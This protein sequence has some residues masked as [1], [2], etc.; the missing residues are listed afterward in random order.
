MT[1]FTPR[2][3]SAPQPDDEALRRM[4][5]SLL[6]QLLVQSNKLQHLPPLAV[7]ASFIVNALI[8]ALIWAGREEA[9]AAAG[10][11][12]VG[13]AA[14]WATL[15]LL[16]RAGRSHGPDRP[17][18]LALS[19]VL[20]L[21]LIALGLFGAP[22][23]MALLAALALLGLVVYSTWIEPFNLQVT[24]QTLD[25][26]GW[27]RGKPV[28]LLHVGD[29][30]VERSGPRER[31]LNALIEQLQP[32][33]IVFSGDFVSLSYTHDERAKA[34]IRAIISRW[35][36]PLGVYVVPGTPMVEPLP[37][38]VEFT[39]ALDNLTL[40]PNRW[41]T[42]DTPRGAL[43]ILG[44][45][46][47]HLIETDRASLERL[48]AQMPATGLKLLLTHAP[49]LAP[50][51]AEAGFDLYLCGHTHGGQIRLP[52]LGAVFSGS[53]FGQQFI[54]GRYALKKM[55]LYTTRGV[56][57]EGLG[58]PRARFL[59]PPEIV[60]WELNGANQ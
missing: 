37:R 3:I 52:L 17:S 47:T 15:W 28:R 55:T 22:L 45:I 25:V 19:A 24:R 35:S 6:H 56:G 51:A 30:H 4:E 20:T 58:A 38:V 13:S 33:V 2:E 7:A 21:I 9:T 8:V 10:I 49:D 53:A 27:T 44:L 42:V 14:M 50:D 40:T 18:A 54:K 36:A 46:T 60:L 11:G 39:R 48:T 29:I 59:C 31:R 41:V 1:D 23:W 16:P 26:P 5:R 57:L 34:D 12:L 43:H 32:D